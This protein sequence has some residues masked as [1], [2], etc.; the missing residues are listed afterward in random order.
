MEQYYAHS[1][2]GS[3]EWETVE[4]HLKRVGELCSGFAQ[5]LQCGGFGRIAGLLHDAG[6][7]SQLFQE[8]LHRQRINIDHA[9]PGAVLAC[10]FG[11]EKS[12]HTLEVIIR[13]HHSSLQEDV[14]PTILQAIRGEAREVPPENKV[15]SVCG[16][17]EFLQLMPLVQQE[18][19]LNLQHD[20]LQKLP[21]L[22]ASPDKPLA[23]MLQTRMLYSCLVDADY[24]ATSE[25]YEKDYLQKTSGEPLQPPKLLKRLQEHRDAI[26]ASS[27]SD[28]KLNAMRD[29]LYNSCIQAAEQ[30][31]GLFTLT[32]PTGLGK[33]LDLLAFALVHAEKWGKER[34]FVVLPYLSIIEQNAKEYRSIV[35]GMLES[36][37][38]VKATD[39]TRQLSERWGAPMIVTTTVGFLEGLF[40][41][42]APDCRH[43]HQ[44]ANSV[45]VLDEAQSLP[46]RLL[47]ATLH[48]LQ[49]LCEHCGCTVVLSTATQPAFQY[50]RN[51]QWYPREIVPDP[52]KLFLAAR[53][54]NVEW[55]VEKPTP[56][57]QIAD[58][59]AELPS[60]CAIM[61]LRRHARKLYSLLKQ[62]C[63]EDELFFLS[64]D[65]CPAHRE[66][67]LDEVRSRLKQGIPCRLVSTQCIEAGVD[68]DFACMYRALAPLESVIQ[69]AGRCNRN[70][71]SGKLGQVTVFVPDEPGRLYPDSWYENAANKLRV[72]LENHDVD[73]CSL[74]DIE[75]YYRRVYSDA[76]EDS[77]KLR[78]AVKQLDYQGAT[79]AY[80]VI[81]Q[82]GCSVIVSYS[83]EMELF[84]EVRKE[85]FAHGLTSEL[86]ARAR[87]I[88][89][90]T[91]DKN[92][93]A[94]CC[95]QLPQFDYRGHRLS[96][97]DSTKEKSNTFLLDQ[98]K[99]Y[100][101]KTGLDFSGDISFE[102]NF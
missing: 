19:G 1:P 38:Q 30:S 18:T 56:L 11:K 99:C 23:Q 42:R 70:G 54:V 101:D 4:H 53:R 35:P 8:V 33:T 49:E 78:N 89:V 29:D 84:A 47:D 62:R 46:P 25:Y 92:G 60:V 12:A 48:T 45:V 58:E 71:G 17:E 3:G 98:P 55:R 34:I 51:M 87:P 20:T 37:S 44:I 66:K 9:V 74:A 24:S 97:K 76:P 15:L 50:R 27:T 77:E 14:M 83:G 10:A 52:Q 100:S 69:A 68:V 59:M 96:A 13:A 2:D 32:A 28:K 61:N 88:T 82:T 26:R 95:E 41:C 16:K 65:L 21:N 31:P 73:L 94:E 57:E 64:S 40:A 43:L 6:K 22:D 81:E 75:E 79:D 63:G 90:N 72:M 80:H 102:S 91:F 7:N 36:H 5:K 39:K 67:V 85:A 93:V 86:L